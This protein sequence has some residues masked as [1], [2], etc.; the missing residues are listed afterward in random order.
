MIWAV[1]FRGRL[2]APQLPPSALLRPS[3]H[4]WVWL[5]LILPKTNDDSFGL[6]NMPSPLWE[7]SG[8]GGERGVS[9]SL[10]EVL[11]KALLPS[12]CCFWSGLVLSRSSSEAFLSWI[13]VPTPC[14]PH[15]PVSSLLCVGS[16]WF[17]WVNWLKSKEPKIPK[18]QMSHQAPTAELGGSAGVL[19]G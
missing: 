4:S 12:H 6:L 8:R 14:H 2:A 17:F 13:S 10:D 1:F 16:V 11:I 3:Q 18:K 15:A 5:V 19:R 9:R 7:N